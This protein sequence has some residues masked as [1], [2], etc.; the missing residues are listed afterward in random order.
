MDNVTHS[1]VGA[2]LGQTGLKRLSG[3]AMPT[4]IVAANL[5]DIDA[6][7]TVFGIESLAMRRGL[8]HG[9]IAWLVLPVL[10]TLGMVMF[11]R[12]QV[13]RG[14]RPEAR[15]PVR[16]GSL[17]LLAFLACLTHPALDWL[18]NYGIRWLEPF[19]SRWFYGDALFIADVWLW[20]VLALGVW[21]SL[22]R[23][24]RGKPR[25]QRPAL[26]ALAV[27][28]IYVNANIAISRV[29]AAAAF[30]AGGSREIVV[31]NPV[32]LAF[33]RRTVLHGGGGQWS[34]RGYDAF[35]GLSGADRQLSP[36]WTCREWPRLADLRARDPRLDAF[37]FWSR[38]PFA[39]VAKEG[40]REVMRFS[41]ARFAE[42][43]SAGRFVV[44][45][46]LRKGE[47]SCG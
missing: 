29:A 36:E 11:D 24:R 12:R 18:N 15:L 22:R 46:P 20:A 16:P 44:A 25:W 23:D 9:P 40:G 38:M 37:L 45:V 32:P 43:L 2:V 47:A 7:S 14:T 19:S 41:D 8:T 42:G 1:L 3:L 5:P 28:L 33:W 21:L 30:R 26:I 17:F 39:W 6:F 27:G 13:R 4:L 31:A 10:L 35:G 34:A